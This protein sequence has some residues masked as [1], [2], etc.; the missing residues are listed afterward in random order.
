G[1]VKGFYDRPV[2]GEPSGGG[3]VTELVA[4]PLVS[5]LF[6]HL[7]PFVQPLAGEYGGRRAL[8]EQVPFTGGYGVE[9]GLLVDL[10]ARFGTAGMAQVD[11]GVRVHRNRSLEDLGPQAT[12]ILQTALARV[13]AGLAPDVATLTRPGR[14]PVEVSAPVLPPMAEVPGYARRSA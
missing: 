8:L 9:L 12:V 13:S 3:R 6:P 5:V 4:R 10:A 11:L 7:A 2:D 1:F 14:E